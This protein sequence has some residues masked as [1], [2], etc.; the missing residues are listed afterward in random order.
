MRKS[1]TKAKIIKF[2]TDM[3]ISIVHRFQINLEKKK[4]QG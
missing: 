1:K 4:S 2:I 3:L